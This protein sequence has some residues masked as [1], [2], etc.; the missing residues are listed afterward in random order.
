MLY[1]EMNEMDF[2]RKVKV[3]EKVVSVLCITIGIHA[4]TSQRTTSLAGE[5]FSEAMRNIVGCFE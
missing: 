4:A 1:N 3:E 5:E 2:L